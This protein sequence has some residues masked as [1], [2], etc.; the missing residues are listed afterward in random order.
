MESLESIETEKT[1]EKINFVITKFQTHRRSPAHRTHQIGLFRLP[2]RSIL[3]N[4][5]EAT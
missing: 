3:V 1:S 5:F 2:R 4:G